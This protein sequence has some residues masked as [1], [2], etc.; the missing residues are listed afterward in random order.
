MQPG[1]ETPPPAVERDERQ[2]VVIGNRA[3]IASLQD[4]APEQIIDEDAVDSYAVGTVGELLDEVR[5]E[6]G[7][8]EVSYLVNGVPVRNRGDIADLPVEALE[9]VEALPRGAAQRIGGAAGQRAYNIVL[10]RSLDTTTLTASREMAT[11]GGWS[12]TRGEALFTAIKGQDRINVTLRASHSGTLF[13]SEREFIPR[14]DTIPF[15]ALGNIVPFSGTQIDPALDAL[16]GSPVS[17][18]ALSAGDVH[19]TLIS[20]AA[21]AG[22]TNPSDL[23]ANRSLRGASRPLEFAV[24]GNKQFNEWLALSFNGRMNLSTSE[25]FSGLPSGRFRILPSNQFSPFA[26]SVYLALNDPERPLRS[27]SESTI[28][29]VGTTLNATFGP[30]HASLDARYDHRERRSRSSS[31]GPLGAA[32][33]VE[34][35][36]NPFDG[37][38]A[39]TIP[40][41]D[42][43]ST[44]NYSSPQVTL[45]G[46]GP[47]LDLWAGPIFT[48]FAFGA[49]WI[50]LDSSDPSGERR[51]RRHEYSTNVGITVPLTGGERQFLSTLG[52]SELSLDIGRTDL[53]GYGTLRSYAFAL[54]LQ[55]VPWLR[56]VA[57]Q[58]RDDHAIVPELEAAPQVITPNV[59]YFDPLTGDTVDVT[60]IYGGSTGLVPESLRTRTL[61]AT[62]TPWKKYSLRLNADYFVNDLDN[63]IGALPPPSSAVVL[64]F[65][66]RFR[67]DASGTL[68]QVDSST[69][70]FARQH[71]EQL[72]LGA[73]FA[74]ELVAGTITPAVGGERASTRRRTPPLRLQVNA[75]QTILLESNSVIRQ[76][77][78][79]VDL[80]EGGAIGIGGGRERNGTDIGLALTRAGSGLRVSAR[81][82]G[83]SYLLIGTPAAPD[84]LTFAPLTTV[85]LKLFTDLGDLF[86]SRTGLKKTRITLAFDNVGNERQRVTN[87]L[88]ET[89][90]AYQPVRR[91]PLGRTI[92]VELRRVF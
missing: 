38:L 91:D 27:S 18:V 85:D 62:V 39:S 63:Q 24:A 42:R 44:S 19:P 6:N 32:G 84:L 8:D 22:R 21:G 92:L 17:I 34:T 47:L 41:I 68:I 25:N 37:T 13:E 30:W 43:L 26:S 81:R 64:A 11:E 82:R 9:R 79:V 69:V 67:R 65:P 35:T 50:K 46:E 71:T 74:V 86:P 49:A 57:S 70:N 7:D 29:S 15:S 87:S 4:F 14:A 76:G 89:P 58:S 45:E 5:S 80:L 54:N 51:F 2:I 10:K 36:R 28:G 40:V 75:A 88:G 83:T 55:P 66:D 31:T 53:G 12:N 90:Q 1:D 48:R 23:A 73:N 3:I 33:T 56:L 52:E 72:R 20:L 59:P 16:V 61:S 60:T 77:L 78:P